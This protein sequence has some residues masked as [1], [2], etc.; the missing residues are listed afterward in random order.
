MYNKNIHIISIYF[1][2]TYYV[3]QI[4]IT[5]VKSELI[6]CMY[7]RGYNMPKMNSA[8]KAY[9]RLVPLSDEFIEDL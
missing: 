5:L 7:L 9:S 2:P 3:N 1:L 8:F 4:I 6:I